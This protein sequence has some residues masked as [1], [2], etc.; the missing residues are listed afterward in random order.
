MIMERNNTVSFLNIL[1]SID[2]F[3]PVGAFTLSNGLEDY[4]LRE[5]LTGSDDLRRYL[6][7]FMQIFPYNDLGILSHAYTHFDDMQYIIE[8]DHIAAASKSASEVRAG[9]IR[10]CA[11]YLK[12]RTAMGDC[13]GQ[14][15]NY[16]NAVAHKEALGIHPITLGIYGAEVK[17]EQDILL[18]MYGY[19]VLSTMVN[20]AV[21]LVPLSQMDGQ[22]ILYE[23]MGRMQE[24]AKKAANIDITEI[25]VSGAAYE[26]HCMNHEK[27][28]SRQYSS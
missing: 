10:M 15:E 6:K 22:K 19:S 9:T 21:K 1:Q 11:R 4:V 24:F 3:F 8:L 27:L 20:N 25:G 13:P 18:I 5:R 7:G 26:I 17:I 23:C 28:Y 16:G 12:A 14:L 2:A